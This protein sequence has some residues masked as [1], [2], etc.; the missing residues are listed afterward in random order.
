MSGADVQ[1]QKPAAGFTLVETLIALFAFSLLMSAGAAMLMAALGGQE[2]LRQTSE[3]MKRLDRA[4]ALIRADLG[5][6]IARL[7]DTG[8]AGEGERGLY[9]GPPGRDGV[10][11]GL[12]RSGWTNIDAAEDRS[13]LLTVEYIFEDNALNRRLI[14]RPDRVRATPTSETVLLEGLDDLDVRFYG[15][16]LP[17]EIWGLTFTEEGVL[18]P[19][20]VEF[21]MTFSNGEV[22]TQRFPVGGRPQ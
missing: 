2:Q 10:V 21:V 5:H 15:G 11:L 4:T 8:R 3:T 18:L 16:G 6:A 7:A 22:L 19:D 9:G 1:S 13:E 17:A 12:V 14:L 20:A